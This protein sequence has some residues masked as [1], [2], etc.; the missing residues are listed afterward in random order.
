MT[1]MVG[2]ATNGD[3]YW[4]AVWSVS[5]TSSAGMAGSQVAGVEAMLDGGFDLRGV[6]PDDASIRA[7]LAAYVVP[8]LNAWMAANSSRWASGM[9]VYAVNTKDRPTGSASARTAA[10]LAQWVQVTPFGVELQ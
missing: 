1:Y 9:T 5:S 2:M 8:K 3:A 10:R 7:Y 6:Q 4:V